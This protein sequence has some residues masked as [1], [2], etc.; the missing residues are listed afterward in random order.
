[1]A[2][3]AAGGCGPFTLIRLQ[4]TF[5]GSRF[6]TRL[7]AEGTACRDAVIGHF[8]L[9]MVFALSYGLALCALYIWAERWRRFAPTPLGSTGTHPVAQV[10]AVLHPLAPVF[11]VAPLVA[12]GLDILV[13]NPLL[14][15]AA[16]RAT[17][18][19]SLRELSTRVWFGSAAGAVKW[20]LL[21]GTMAALGGELF[22]GPRGI[23]IRR[24]RFCAIAVGLGALPLLLFPQGQDILQRLVEGTDPL[25]RIGFGVLAIVFAGTIVW[26]CG[27]KLMQMRFSDGLTDPEDAEWYDF[28]ARNLPRMFG[29][30]ILAL[31][32]AAFARAGLATQG[33]VIGGGAGLVLV[34]LG[35]RR[36][37]GV[38]QTIGR[39]LV[40]NRDTRDFKEYTQRL[41][42]I[43]VAAVVGLWMI[44]PF[45]GPQSDRLRELRIAAWLCLTAAWW[46]YLRVYYGRELSN[47]RARTKGTKE[48][49]PTH[50]MPGAER[51]QIEATRQVW[52]GVIVSLLFLALFTFVPVQ[53]AR[54]LGPIWVLALA[55][56]TA[57]FYGTIAVWLHARRRVPVVKLA[58]LLSMAFGLWNENH[59]VR[60]L[61]PAGVTDAPERM[62]LD[63]HFDEWLAA[64]TSTSSTDT[65]PII[66]VA[67]AG[68]GIRAAYWTAATLAVA[69]DADSAFARH[70]FAISGVSGGSLGA[71]VFSALVKDA[72]S[73]PSSLRCAGAAPAPGPGALLT[74]PYGRCVRRFMRDD[75]LSPVLAKMVAPDLVQ[76]FLPIPLR[77]FDRSRGL[78][79]SWVV[80]YRNA[81]SKETFS[82]GL[83]SL[84]GDS[85][86]RVNVPA[87]LLNSTHVESGNR[88]IASPFLVDSAFRSS[89]DVITVLRSDLPLATAVHNSAR[90]TYVSPAGHLDR[91]DGAELGRVVDGGYFENSGLA[92]LGEV[93]EMV[94]SRLAASPPPRPVRTVVVYL[95][96]DPLS[97]AFDH[98][99]R[100]DRAPSTSANEL[101][102]PVRALLNTRS[103]RGSLSHAEIRSAPGVEFMQI[104]VCDRLTRSAGRVAEPPPAQSPVQSAAQTTPAAVDSAAMADVAPERVVAPPLGWLLSRLARD[105]MDSSLVARGNATDS[106]CRARNRDQL[107]RLDEL[108]R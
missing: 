76:R 101:L 15:W 104:D 19:D 20:I 62:A 45:W 2:G 53:S 39:A 11:I 90:F 77:T 59:A 66:L 5:S 107:R 84:A 6:A 13:E 99:R 47:R 48:M 30:A 14:W 49:Q 3:L 85:T 88:Y 35:N 60:R 98:K 22:A 42:A 64:R 87:L 67:A 89:A 41:G 25:I 18:A 100:G 68:G 36:A 51:I 96:N 46:L 12:A 37:P 92:T 32:A 40:R 17:T 43:A 1:M 81:T 8:P 95:C 7:N 10:P 106:E 55:V 73:A 103:A 4:V 31:S 54:L 63:A 38:L 34:L 29:V 86:A 94:R 28:Y 79:D 57:V 83:L 91:G 82:E 97:C 102:G 65:L 27:R 26:Y 108:V 24:L 50:D 52:T 70:V 80:S 71:A 93:Y 56:A 75:F 61:A 23:V 16:S 44:R 105:W 33:F 69:Q 9:D 72:G 58:L 21:L 74:S 78:E